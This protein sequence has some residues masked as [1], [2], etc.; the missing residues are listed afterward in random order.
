MEIKFASRVMRFG[1]SPTQE[2]RAA[3]TSRTADG[4]TIRPDQVGRAE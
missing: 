1:P 3:E 2:A 4:L